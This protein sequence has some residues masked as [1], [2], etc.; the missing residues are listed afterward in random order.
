MLWH[1]SHLFTSKQNFQITILQLLFELPQG[2]D[3]CVN[4]NSNTCKTR[5]IHAVLIWCCYSYMM[6]IIQC[7]KIPIL[8][9]L[10]LRYIKITHMYTINSVLLYLYLSLTIYVEGK[11][12]YWVDSDK[13]VS[14]LGELNNFLLLNMCIL[15]QTKSKL[16]AIIIIAIL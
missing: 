5:L 12:A 8:H 13:A 4:A 6:L 10:L 16:W 14:T 1:L 2:D 3:R 9:A 15:K 11:I 7:I